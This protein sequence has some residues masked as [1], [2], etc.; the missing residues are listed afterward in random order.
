VYIYV[1]N[2]NSKYLFYNRFHLSWIVLLFLVTFPLAA[3]SVYGT[4]WL[5]V[6]VDLGRRRRGSGWEGGR[7]RHRRHPRWW[8]LSSVYR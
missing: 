7:W 6:G 2:L 8:P 4:S 5:H 1:Y 3:L